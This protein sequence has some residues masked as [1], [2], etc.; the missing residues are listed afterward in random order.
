[1]AHGKLW[2]MEELDELNRLR[3]AGLTNGEIAE[4]LGRTEKAI[5][6]KIRKAKLPLKRARWGIG[7]AAEP[8]FDEKNMRAQTRNYTA[9]LK[10][11]HPERWIDVDNRND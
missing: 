4:C 2:S 8:A 11:A 10:E 3:E 6:S 5:N 1:M 7:E 9:A